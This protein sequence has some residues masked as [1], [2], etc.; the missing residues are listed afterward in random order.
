M[1]A[2]DVGDMDEA[3]DVDVLVEFLD[4]IAFGDLLV[5][6]VVEKLHL[7]VVD[8]ADDVNG[9]GGRWQEVVGVLFEIDAFEKQAHGLAVDLFAFNERSGALEAFDAALMLGLARETGNDVAG[10]DDHRRAGERFHRRESL[11]QL[12]EKGIAN[13]WIADSV[14]QPGG[15]IKVDT[16]T[17]ARGVG[18]GEVGVGPFGV[19]ADQLDML[20]SGL[21]NVGKA[22][23]E[24]KI[25][26]RRSRA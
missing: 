11:A 14:M 21:G 19:F 1:A 25:S 16:E 6:D 3:D 23:F 18:A 2:G 9:F 7:R 20:V 8:G 12:G 17:F 26:S 15:C 10:E 22:L 4:E 5:E 13:G 24:G